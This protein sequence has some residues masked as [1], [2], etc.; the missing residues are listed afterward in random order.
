MSELT[1]DELLQV[2]SM[3]PFWAAA[4]EKRFTVERCGKCGTARFPAR[5]V[6]PTCGAGDAEWI[7]DA[8]EGTVYSVTTTMRAV[9]EDGP[10]PPYQT[11]MVQ[12]DAGVLFF[13]RLATGES[14][15]ID[16]RVRITFES[17]PNGLVVPVFERATGKG[18]GQST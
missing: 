12:M 14:V 4:Q 3:A 9:Y 13:A 15:D 18:N 11:A 1:L 6:C 2:R 17:N 8:G 7:D 10:P 16:D 5:V